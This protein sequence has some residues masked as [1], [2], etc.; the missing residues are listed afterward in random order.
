[1]K[2]PVSHNFKILNYLAPMPTS[3]ASSQTTL[4]P[5]TGATKALFLF[6]NTYKH[7][8]S[9]HLYTGRSCYEL[10][11]ALYRMV[12]SLLIFQISAYHTT[13]RGLSPLAF[14][15]MAHHSYFV[16]LLLS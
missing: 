3:S 14:Y 7:L 11:S 9:R 13:Q 10:T 4:S 15:L 5:S 12:G 6:L 16:V 1:M 2:A 8:Q